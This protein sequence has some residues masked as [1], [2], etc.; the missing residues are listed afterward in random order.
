M[1]YS[2]EF[3]I[4]AG[5][6]LSFVFLLY[7]FV[8]LYIILYQRLQAKTWVEIDAKLLDARVV[9]RLISKD[10]ELLKPLLCFFASYEYEGRSYGCTRISFYPRENAHTRSAIKS[11]EGGEREIIRLFVDPKEPHRSVLIE[12]S[13]HRILWDIFKAVFFVS[14][15][16]YMIY[17][18]L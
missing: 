13:Q 1:G 3:L 18:K 11:L 17:L 14:I 7:S 10:K 9:T 12:P 6:I 15:I 4:R 8:S 2:P 16:I 5:Y